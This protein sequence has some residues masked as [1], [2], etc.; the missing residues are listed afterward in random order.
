MMCKIDIHTPD[1]GDDV[2]NDA[3]EAFQI[4]FIRINASP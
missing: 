3:D 1:D 2:N 4:I